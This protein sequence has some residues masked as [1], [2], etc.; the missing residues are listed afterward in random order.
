MVYLDRNAIFL[1]TGDKWVPTSLNSLLD[2][3]G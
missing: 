1:Q 3:V 2:S